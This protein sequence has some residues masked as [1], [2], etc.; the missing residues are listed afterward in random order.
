[1][2]NSGGAFRPWAVIARS[3]VCDC[4]SILQDEAISNF[5]EE[6]A[7]QKPLAMTRA[8]NVNRTRTLFAAHES[9]TTTCSWALSLF[10]PYFPDGFKKVNKYLKLG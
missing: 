4:A 2:P 9:A 3:V 8:P 1:M 7:S 10:L 5:T 6:I